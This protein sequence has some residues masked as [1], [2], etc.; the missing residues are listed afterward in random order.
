MRMNLKYFGGVDNTKIPNYVYRWTEKEVRKLISSYNPKYN[1]T[2]KF[3]YEFEYE[4][5]LEKINNSFIKKI[6]NIFL[7]FIIK[8][9]SLVFKKQSNLFSF[10]IDKED[11]EKFKHKW[12]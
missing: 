7:S 6:I 2:I 5:I 11:S 3:N 9:L 4:N 8:I 1:H 10:F 12:I